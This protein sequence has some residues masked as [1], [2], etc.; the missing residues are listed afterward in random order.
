MNLPNPAMEQAFSMPVLFTSLASMAP[1]GLLQVDLALAKWSRLL[2]GTP[3]TAALQKCQL[4]LSVVALPMRS[5]ESVLAV[6]LVCAGEVIEVEIAQTDHPGLEMVK[7]HGTSQAMRHLAFQAVFEPVTE[8]LERLGL[9][10]WRLAGVAKRK[11]LDI[12]IGGGVS[13]WLCVVQRATSIA[14]LR[15]TRADADWA[16]RANKRLCSQAQLLPLSTQWSLPARIELHAQPYS[17]SLLTG[18]E[19]GDVL[20]FPRRV[21]QAQ[22]WSV[23]VRWGATGRRRAQSVGRIEETQVVIE[24]ATIMVNEEVGA[25]PVLDGADQVYCVADIDIPVRFELESVPVPLSDLQ[26]LLPGYVI[27]LN[28]PLDRATLRVVACGQVIALAEL[29]AVG[30][31]L[32]ARVTRMGST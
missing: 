26:A 22:A 18:L 11:A 30:D 13:P 24:G 7:A 8:T 6:E 19:P 3:L 14:T 16:E 5:F 20:L 15:I 21:D 25:E 17:R 29:V 31:H 4:Q 28:C 12:P 2:N 23:V 10:R 9:G 32:G 27:Q 1:S